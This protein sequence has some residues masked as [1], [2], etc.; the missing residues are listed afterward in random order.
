MDA[1]ETGIDLKA[2]I[3]GRTLH[4]CHW[5]SVLPTYPMIIYPLPGRMP[6]WTKGADCKS[7]IRGFESH[8]G[9]WLDYRGFPDVS[10]E[11]ALTMHCI[12]MIS[13]RTGLM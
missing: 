13:T 10:P 11:S 3:S 5:L 1:L 9:L 6:E 2:T 4:P 12:W 7:V 8:S